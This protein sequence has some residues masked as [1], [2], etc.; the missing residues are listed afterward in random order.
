MLP[1]LVLPL[2]WLLLLPTHPQLLQRAQLLVPLPPLL[3]M[4]PAAP[5]QSSPAVGGHAAG[6]LRLL[7]VLLGLPILVTQS[8]CCLCFARKPLQSAVTLLDILDCMSFVRTHLRG[9]CSSVAG[10]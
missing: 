5:C 1:L 3:C 9:E 10:D 6:H 8:L 4:N 2:V 7:A